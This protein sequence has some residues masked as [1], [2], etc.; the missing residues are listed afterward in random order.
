MTCVRIVSCRSADFNMFQMTYTY[1]SVSSKDFWLLK[2]PWKKVQHSES[3]WYAH[4]LRYMFVVTLSCPPWRLINCF[5]KDDNQRRDFTSGYYSRGNILSK[6]RTFHLFETFV[7]GNVRC[8]HRQI[9]QS[10]AMS[11]FELFS[12][13]TPIKSRGRPAETFTY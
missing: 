1:N 7:V 8:K 2:F 11:D 9:M 6:P 3:G 13:T 5:L 12:R 10:Y 4:D